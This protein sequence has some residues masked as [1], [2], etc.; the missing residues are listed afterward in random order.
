MQQFKKIQ[1]AT[2]TNVVL[3]NKKKLT[4]N[5]AGNLPL[6][7][8]LQTRATIAHVLPGINKTSL[9]SIGQLCDDGCLAIFDK[10]N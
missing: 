8:S 2:N 10:R 9:L 3:P 6:A 5:K 4:T 1:R 7:S